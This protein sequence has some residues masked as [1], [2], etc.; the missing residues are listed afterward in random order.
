[1]L[2]QKEYAPISKGEPL[3]EVGRMREEQNAAQ[4]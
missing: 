2:E 1:M 4:R 3:F